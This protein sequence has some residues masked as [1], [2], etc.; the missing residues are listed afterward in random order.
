MSGIKFMANRKVP[1]AILAIITVVLGLLINKF[2]IENTKQNTNDAYIRADISRISPQIAGVITEV[3]VQDNQWVK[4]GELLAVID[5]R[6]FNVALSQAKAQLQSAIARQ[7]DAKA[8]L[9]R[10][11]ALIAAAQAQLQSAQAELQ[12]ARQEHTRYQKM[13]ASGAGSQQAAQ[14]ATTRVYTMSASVAQSEASLKAAKNM[15]QVLQ[16]KQA[17]SDAELKF[18]QAKQAMAVLNLS[19]TQITAPISGIIGKK[20]LR[21]GEFVKPGD[22]LMAI[23]PQDK[24]YIIANYQE[25]Q[26][27][28]ITHGQQVDINIDT[29]PGQTLKGYVDSI[30][31][32]SGAS[33]SPV[34]PENATGNFTK[35]VQRIPVKIIFDNN[36]DQTTMMNALR[37]GMSA[38]VSINTLNGDRLSAQ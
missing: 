16:A 11:N 22:A 25:T 29:F 27:E 31:P 4:Q 2:F 6:E 26:L 15:L 3:L 38:D 18:A 20:S 5:Q 1:L 12:F 32:A 19:Y 24:L 35:I 17:D 36:K 23:V 30:A 9:T 7:D 37:V 10:Q 34:A 8:S 14:Q 33:F 21:I 13:A 28:K